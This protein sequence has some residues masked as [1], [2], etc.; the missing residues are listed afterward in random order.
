V[1]MLRLEEKEEEEKKRDPRKDSICSEI[2]PGSPLQ[3]VSSGRELN[4]VLTSSFSPRTTTQALLMFTVFS[5]AINELSLYI[6]FG[7]F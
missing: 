6:I 2:F 7:S 4:F 3:A 1:R 5:V